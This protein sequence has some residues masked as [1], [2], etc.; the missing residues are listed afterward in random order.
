M[1]AFYQIRNF[2]ACMVVFGILLVASIGHA[3]DDAAKCEGAPYTDGYLVAAVGIKNCKILRKIERATEEFFDA[4]CKLL[5]AKQRIRG[6]HTYAVVNELIDL[7]QVEFKQASTLFVDISKQMDGSITLVQNGESEKANQILKV[8][9][10]SAPKTYADAFRILGEVTNKA[11]DQLSKLEFK[12]GD[13]RSPYALDSMYSLSGA[14]MRPGGVY[15]A[16]A[17]LFRQ[18]VS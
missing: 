9:G 12:Q 7:A 10:V 1:R 3:Q 5:E 14:M 15:R 4:E 11:A 18:G 16:I 17:L 6:P 8:Y 2:A 13:D